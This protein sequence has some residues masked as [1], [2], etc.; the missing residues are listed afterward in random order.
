MD[1]LGNR[2]LARA[3]FYDSLAAAIDAGLPIDQAITTSAPAGGVS[4]TAIL[5]LVADVTAGKDFATALEKHVDGCTSSEVA[6]VKA[7]EGSG[8]L[9]LALSRLGEYLNSSA[10]LRRQLVWQLAYPVGLVHAAILLP[11]LP[12]LFR[13]GL[14][15][16]LATA[17]S[18]TLWVYGVACAF[19]LLFKMPLASAVWPSV[20]VVRTLLRS[21]AVADYSFVLASLLGAGAALPESLRAAATSVDLASFRAAGLRVAI[22]VRQGAS[23]GDAFA[24]DEDV[25]GAVLVEQVRIGETAGKLDDMLAKSEAFARREADQAAKLLAVGLSGLAFIVAALVVGWVVLDFWS[26][27]AETLDIARLQ[28]ARLQ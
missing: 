7:G 6:I 14:G 8:R 17:G 9:P 26:G 10:T 20:P 4:Q 19:W 3:K 12:V 11:T 25:F 23:L 18:V 13:S 22:A 5:A 15:S 24:T 27:Y 21:R 1:L 28:G 2:L 16:Y